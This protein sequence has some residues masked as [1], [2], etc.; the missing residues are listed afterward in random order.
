MTAEERKEFGEYLRQLREASGL[1][2]RQ[3]GA[4]IGV[5]NTYLH[6]V[7]KGDRN[8][9]ITE[10]LHAIADAY[11]VPRSDVMKAAKRGEAAKFEKQQTD[12]LEH[13]FQFVVNH[14]RFAYGNQSNTS[15]MTP[16]AKRLIIHMFEDLTGLKILEDD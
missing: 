7:E 16:E 10:K 8:P 15:E 14:R 11:G 3:A 2:L 13:A 6:Q 9:P 12:S 1:S 5:S 4:K